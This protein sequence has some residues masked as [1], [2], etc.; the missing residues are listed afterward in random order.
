MFESTLDIQVQVDQIT[1]VDR[2]WDDRYATDRSQLARVNVYHPDSRLGG[3]LDEN[4]ALVPPT[5]TCIDFAYGMPTDVA[6]SP[7]PEKIVMAFQK[8][9]MV[10]PDYG[11][12]LL[13]PYARAARQNQAPSNPWNS[14]NK[15]VTDVCVQIVSYG[16]SAETDAEIT[17]FD[18][19]AEVKIQTAIQAQVETLAVYQ[20]AGQTYPQEIKATWTLI[21]EE[22][23]QGQQGRWRIDSVAVNSTREIR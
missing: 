17:A 16:P 11:R 23:E 6:D 9:F 20:V 15:A 7:Y 10:D 2:R 21:R 4:Q 3:Y 14:F 5:S 22:Q 8:V 12:N 13:T 19:A 18:N 1:V